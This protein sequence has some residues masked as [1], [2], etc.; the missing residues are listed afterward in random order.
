M[1][2][3]VFEV[4]FDFTFI[5]LEFFRLFILFKKVSGILSIQNSRENGRL[6]NFGYR[7][8]CVF[9]FYNKVVLQINYVF[10]KMKNEIS[11]YMFIY[12]Y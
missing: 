11:K 3:I 2:N 10:S 12:V 1:V 6:V 4:I 8:L 9:S 7:S 5:K